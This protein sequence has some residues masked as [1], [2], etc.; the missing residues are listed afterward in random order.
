MTS[1]EISQGRMRGEEREGVAAFLGIPYA[2]PPVGPL[3]LRPPQPAPAWHGTRDA[4]RWGAAQPQREDPIAA[5]LGLLHGAPVDE[6]CLTLNVYTPTARAAPRPVLVWL[7]GGAFIG[8]TAGIP[9]YDATRLAARGDVVVVTF[10]YRVGALGFSFLPAPGGAHVANLGLLDQLAALR[11]VRAQIGAFGG[12]VRNVTLF[13]ES[14]GAGSILAL[15]GMPAAA[16][17]FDRAIVQS[18]AP[19]GV[20]RPDEAEARS[21]SVLAKLGATGPAAEALRAAPLGA[22]LE[23][24]YACASSGPHRTGMFYVPVHDGRTLAVEPID[25][26]ATGFGRRIPL[27]IGTTRDEM[28]LFYTGKPD[29]DELALLA[30]GAQLESLPPGERPGAARELIALHRAQRAARGEPVGPADLFLAVQSD[31]SLRYHATRIAEARAPQR[32]TWMYLFTWRSPLAGGIH[33]A[34]HGL[35][36]PFTFGNLDA[37]RMPEFAGAGEDAQRLAGQMMDAWCAFA[38]AG[39]PSHAGIGAWP[40]YDPARRATMELGARCRVVDAPLEPERAA[41]ARLAFA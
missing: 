32:N 37:P 10:N 39:D 40:S 7:H 27:L 16:G 28:R 20:L 14:A 31:L 33:G 11:W 35:D 6:D 41:L 36:L 23:A 2:A 12:D 38:R 5:S 3:R 4:T 8:G 29:R 19:R 34:C 22:L 30:I 26:F 18:A 24:Q 17:L 21:R 15:A 1:V 13:G 9:L 25:A